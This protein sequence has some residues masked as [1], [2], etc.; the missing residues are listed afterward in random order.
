MSR[1]AF[2]RSETEMARQ[3]DSPFEFWNWFSGLNQL[4]G[5]LIFTSNVVGH[6]SIRRGFALV[7]ALPCD[8]LHLSG[9]SGEAPHATGGYQFSFFHGRRTLDADIHLVPI[10]E[11][12]DY[13][14]ATRGVV[15]SDFI[16][17]GT[18]VLLGLASG[19]FH[20]LCPS[21]FAFGNRT[22][23][24]VPFVTMEGM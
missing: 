20:G 24:L 2:A 4:L 18:V 14:S 15:A 21:T 17:V 7:G 23:M 16:E 1:V 5:K 12:T 6:C 10:G 19:D 3:L 13:V 11:S 9:S 22:R 8:A